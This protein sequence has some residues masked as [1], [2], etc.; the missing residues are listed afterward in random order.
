MSIRTNQD[1]DDVLMGLKEFIF[2]NLNCV[3]IGKVASFDPAKNTAE[4]E[5]QF[6][7]QTED[8]TLV[9]YPLLVDVPIFILSGGGAYIDMPVTAGDYCVILF[10]DRDIDTWWS[11][12]NVKQPNSKRAHSLADGI[13]L[14]GITPQ[15]KVYALDGEKLRIQAEGKIL[16]A[17][18]EEIHLNGDGERLV[19][20]QDLQTVLS[21][22]EALIK[23]HVHPETGATTG[24]SPSLAGISLDISAAKTT[25]IKTGG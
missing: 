14:V 1:L 4:V 24:P 19:T 3:Q 22:A 12:G 21:T 11:S 2:S 13:A 10:N 8:G 25:T 23:N 18:A 16:Q 17:N 20:W 15:S 9:D 7:A 5:I 6:K